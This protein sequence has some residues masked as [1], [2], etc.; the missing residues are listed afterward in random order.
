[1]AGEYFQIGEPLAPTHVD[2]LQ[3][4]KSRKLF[5]A[6]ADN[7]DFDL[8]ELRSVTRSGGRAFEILIVECLCEGV[9]PYNATGIDV[10]ERLAL[11]VFNDVSKLPDTWAM[12]KNF[13]VTGH[14][15]HVAS[16][17]PASLCLYAQSS[18][19]VNRTWTAQGYLRRVQWWLENASEGSL[20]ANDP[21]PEQFFFSSNCELVLPAD[22]YDRAGKPGYGLIFSKF[23]ERKSSRNTLIGEMREL[24]ENHLAQSENALSLTV[25]LDPVVGDRVERE[26]ATL[27]ELENSLQGRGASIMPKILAAI[28]NFVGSGRRSN[29]HQTSI[30]LVL[31]IPLKKLGDEAPSKRHVRAF[32]IFSDPLQ[33]GTKAG[34]LIEQNGIY[35]LDH[36]GKKSFDDVTAWRDIEIEPLEVTYALTPELTRL[37]SGTGETVNDFVLMGGG[38]LGG[39]MLECWIRAGWGK[40]TVID[41][42]YIKPH[43]LAR[44]VANTDAIGQYKADALAIKGNSLFP[45]SPQQIISVPEDALD[46]EKPAIKE[47]IERAALIVDAT[48]TLEVPRKLAG[49][50]ELKRCASAFLTPNALGSVL[51]AEDTNRRFR[52]DALESQYYRFLMHDDL[53]HLQTKDGRIR[54]G[55]GCRD[56]SVVMSYAQVAV[57]AANLAD[58]FQWLDDDPLIKIWSRSPQTGEMHLDQLIPRPPLHTKC[59]D[60]TIIWDEGFR[61]RIFELRKAAL[62]SETGGVLLGYFDLNENKIYVVDAVPAPPDSTGTPESFKRGVIGLAPM[63]DEVLRRTGGVV[64]YIG[65]WHSHPDGSLTAPSADDLLQMLY[66]AQTLD[67]D[68]LPAV[69]MIAGEGDLNWILGEAHRQ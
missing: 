54:T 63:V 64:G 27:G 34:Q 7:D 46:I 28:E 17:M 49:R 51:I 3:F 39:V 5:H 31:D 11:V 56:L 2:S 19:A 69:M 1:M 30:I 55:A 67:Q 62:P 59:G 33:L 60:L 8:I 40:W 48:T 4:G 35:Y 58:Q 26:P 66:L 6:I 20:Y 65:E 68:G 53:D 18:V 23:V 21:T 12:R 13:P 9:G 22:F 57:H 47:A 61:E 10:H 38:A 24:G 43:N 52:L 50:N 15:N 29:P 44:H 41:N 16:G 32:F 37:Y 36:F 42:D 45:G 25:E 14:Q